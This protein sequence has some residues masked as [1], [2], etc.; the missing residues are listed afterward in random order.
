M[1]QVIETDPR[2]TPMPDGSY[3]DH[4]FHLNSHLQFTINRETYKVHPIILLTSKPS[5]ADGQI[6]EI[7]AMMANGSKC[8]IFP[9]ISDRND[10]YGLIYIISDVRKNI[11][12]EE[13]IQLVSSHLGTLTEIVQE[14]IEDIVQMNTNQI[15][16]VLEETDPF[17][18]YTC[19]LVRGEW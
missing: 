3:P 6:F 15:Q 18:K 8:Y 17:I 2:T 5:L 4:T 12:M 19:D 9:T 13:A 10:E 11:S 14:A 16:S 1:L 7:N